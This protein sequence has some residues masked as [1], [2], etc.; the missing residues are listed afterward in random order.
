MA[1]VNEWISQEDIEKYGLIALKDSY[2][3]KD[4][5]GYKESMKLHWCVDKERDLVYVCCLST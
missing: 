1:F 5:S 2:L 3:K 4:Y